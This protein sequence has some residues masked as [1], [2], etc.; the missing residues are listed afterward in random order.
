M[1]LNLIKELPIQHP[2]ELGSNME[3]IGIGILL[4][5]GFYLMP[6]I[7]ALIVFVMA[8]VFGTITEIFSFICRMLGGCK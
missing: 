2:L 7:I 6:V 8:L 3:W 5:I 4:A 1:I